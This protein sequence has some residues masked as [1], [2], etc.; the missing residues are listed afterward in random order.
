[1]IANIQAGIAQRKHGTAMPVCWSI[2]FSVFG[3]QLFLAAWHVRV[4]WLPALD[5]AFS[6]AFPSPEARFGSHPPPAARLRALP[7]ADA[8]VRPAL[9]SKAQAAL[10]AL[11][12]G[13]P[14]CKR[15]G[16]WGGLWGR[17]GVSVALPAASAADRETVE[18]AWGFVKRRS[19]VGYRWC[20]K[21]RS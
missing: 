3:Y 11:L 12:L 9:W 8:A 1:M 4:P 16:L 6:L 14:D 18:A 15:L 19:A 21:R 17:P 10:L 20:W 13:R 5:H 7:H 2:A